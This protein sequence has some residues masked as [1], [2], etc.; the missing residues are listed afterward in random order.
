[1]TREL[2]QI[3]MHFQFNSNFIKQI[4]SDLDEADWKQN[5]GEGNTAL[6]VLGHIAVYRR[7]LLRQIGQEIAEENWEELFKKGTKL[8]QTQT[9]PSADSLI[10]D[11][12]NTGMKITKGLITLKAEDAEK[13]IDMTMPN[14]ENTLNG[15]INFLYFHESYHLGQIGY[16]RRLL[17]KPG[18]R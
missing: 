3:G 2:G 10:K 4:A 18:L 5:H 12:S 1:M 13:T 6:W 15:L 9:N 7:M 11:I 8:D 17:N 16:I 14:G